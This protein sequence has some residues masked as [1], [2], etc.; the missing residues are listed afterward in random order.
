LKHYSLTKGTFKYYVILFISIVIWAVLPVI[1]KSAMG[2]YGPVTYAWLRALTGFLFILPLAIKN[3]FTFKKAF[4]K[5]SFFYGLIA[6]TL[7]TMIYHIGNN[8][9]SA[10]V[11]AISQA[12][13]P[14][15][16]LI[17][18]MIFFKEKAT[19]GKIAGAILATAGIMITCIGGTLIDKN[20]TLLGIFFVSLAPLTWTVYSIFVKKYDSETNPLEIVGYILFNGCIISFPIMMCEWAFFTGL[21]GISSA[22]LL[23][24]VF[25]GPLALGIAN[26]A[27]TYGSTH[28]NSS[29]S[30]L[31]YNFCP[32]LGVIIAAFAGETVSALQITGCAVVVFG[33]IIGIKDEEVFHRKKSAAQKDHKAEP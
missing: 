12:T 25:G 3:G 1:S 14:V 30:G 18:G 9:C 28:L 19:P 4:T 31:L 29:I 24:V 8:M 15:F 11:T 6:F 26:I 2:Y 33:I 27:W 23:T 16:F 13:M 10:N 17:G 5:K 22:A 32:I 7:N 20:T 21:P